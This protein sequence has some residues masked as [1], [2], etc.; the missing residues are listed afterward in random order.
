MCVYEI[1]V[2]DLPV[3]QN[4]EYQQLGTPIYINRAVLKSGRQKVTYRLYPAPKEFNGKNG[5]TF[6]PNTTF[7]VTVYQQDFK[8][9]DADTE[10]LVKE[11]KLHTQ[12]RQV[13]ES[14]IAKVKEFVGKG[15]K[16]YEHTFYF[17]ATV[18]Y[19][20]EGWSKGQ[21]LRK[22]NPDVLKQAVV[23]YYNLRKRMV[24]NKDKD[25]IAKQMFIGLKSNL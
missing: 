4:Y 1:W 25:G 2:N 13:G 15:Q 14:E 20:I 21:D 19:E 3:H 23:K 8:R 11:D 9:P 18:P 17:D 7:D 6:S 5:D 16:Y 12:E 22:L 24:E 10:Q